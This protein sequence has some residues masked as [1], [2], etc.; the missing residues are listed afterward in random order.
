VASYYADTG[1]LVVENASVWGADVLSRLAATLLAGLVV[2]AALSVLTDSARVR[3]PLMGRYLTIVL[4]VTFGGLMAFSVGVWSRGSGVGT[5]D[6]FVGT[7]FHQYGP[8]E[9]GLV[10]VVLV[11]SI[12]AI[13]VS[14]GRILDWTTSRWAL[15]RADTA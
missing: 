4:S 15:A 11:A 7:A 13:Y 14:V 10:A 1:T 2:V 5:I 12:A 9:A 3:R 8:L 6:A